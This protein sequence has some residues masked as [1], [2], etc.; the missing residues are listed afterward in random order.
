M[1]NDLYIPPEAQALLDHWCG[2]GLA[3]GWPS[4]S[5]DQLWFG[6][7]PEQDEALRRHYG[8]LVERALAGGLTDWSATP[9]GRLALVLLLDQLTRNLFRRQPRAFAGDPRAQALTLEAIATG[10]DEGLPVVGRVFLYMPLL[11]AESLALQDEAVRRFE[12]LREQAPAF[13]HAELDDNLRYA[14]LHRDIVARFGRFPHRNEAL[15]RDSTAEER[16]FLT[17]GPRFGQ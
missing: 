5:R 16:A 11:H 8:A 4:E 10:E 6:F 2:D 9:L 13:C 3:R 12:R 7:N 15:G 1:A 17:D 14:R